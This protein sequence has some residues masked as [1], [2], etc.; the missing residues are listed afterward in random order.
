MYGGPRY[1]HERYIFYLLAHHNDDR[2]SLA[3]DIQRR[4]LTV[5]PEDVLSEMQAALLM[6]SGR[7]IR[8][9]R[10]RYGHYKGLWQYPVWLRDLGFEEIHNNP[11][12]FVPLDFFNH[13]QARFITELMLSANFNEYQILCVVSD[14]TGYTLEVPQIRKFRDHC[15]YLD[16]LS[17]RDW[18]SYLDQIASSDANE[19]GIRNACRGDQSTVREVLGL[20]D[21]RDALTSMHRKLLQRQANL[22]EL[23]SYT[24]RDAIRATCRENRALGALTEEIVEEVVRRKM[25]RCTASENR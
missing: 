14:R 16:V 6:T 19:A 25:G 23:A 13:T 1:P 11:E 2:Q 12:Q 17:D 20:A 18:H 4:Q 9:H 8:E 5:P 3:K 22:Q 10:K 7:R 24:T 15:Y 21:E